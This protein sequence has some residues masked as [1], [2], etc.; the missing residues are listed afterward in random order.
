MLRIAPAHVVRMRF[1][2]GLAEVRVPGTGVLWARPD[3]L[4][5]PVFILDNG[6]DPFEQGLVRSLRGGKV[7]FYDRRLRPVLATDYDWAFPFNARGQALVCRGCR[8]DGR[9]PSSM[10]GGAWGLIDRA[11]RVVLPLTED[12]APFKRYFGRS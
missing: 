6:A 2:R 5:L 8:S 1:R 9:E 11:G 10:V 7:A 4:A 3:G 12:D